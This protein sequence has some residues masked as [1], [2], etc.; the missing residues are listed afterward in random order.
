MVVGVYLHQEAIVDVAVQSSNGKVLV[1][2]DC[3]DGNRILGVE[4]RK[5]EY[6]L[7]GVMVP[8]R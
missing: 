5:E 6:S 1:V 4:G 8:Y 7:V 3:F 2:R